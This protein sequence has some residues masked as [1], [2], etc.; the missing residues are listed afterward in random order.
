ML[1]KG[2]VKV[3]KALADVRSEEHTIVDEVEIFKNGGGP[4]LRGVAFRVLTQM[5]N[6]LAFSPIRHSPQVY[7]VLVLNRRETS[8]LK[9]LSRFCEV[10]E[11]YE[12][13]AEDG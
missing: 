13:D 6:H 4:L 1:L 7:D 10:A 9:P 12:P 3:T 8:L 2:G 5:Y 11:V